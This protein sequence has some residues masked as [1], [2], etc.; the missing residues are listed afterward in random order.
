VGSALGG[1]LICLGPDEDLIDVTYDQIPEAAPAGQW[2]VQI[3]CRGLDEAGNLV[4][5]ATSV[6]VTVEAP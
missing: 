6:V 3:Q 4:L 5:G 1:T 2:P